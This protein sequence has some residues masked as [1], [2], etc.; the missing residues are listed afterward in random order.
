[1]VADSQ[2]MLQ[3]EGRQDH[4]IPHREG[5]SELIHLLLHVDH[6]LDVLWD[7]FDVL[8]GHG[9]GGHTA[10]VGAIAG[11]AGHRIGGGHV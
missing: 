10:R 2:V 11:P 4:T 6:G 8:R 7:G 1:M 3:S 5:E 9:P